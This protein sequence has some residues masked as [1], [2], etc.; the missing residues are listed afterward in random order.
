MLSG[1]GSCPGLTAFEDEVRGLNELSHNGDRGDLDRLS[2]T[3]QAL[4]EGL[5]A[6]GRFNVVGLVDEHEPRELFGSRYVVSLDE[7]DA[8]PIDA[9]VDFSSPEGVARSAA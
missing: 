2:A 6:T 8:G 7:L 1:G 5:T 9:V 4:G 3:D